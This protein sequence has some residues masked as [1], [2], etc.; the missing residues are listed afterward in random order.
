[1][2]KEFVALLTWHVFKCLRELDE[3]C[4]TG[5]DQLAAR[6]LKELAAVIALPLS[7]LCRR[8]LYEAC[9]PTRWKLHHVIPIFRNA[10][11]YNPN[12][13]RGVHL[14]SIVSEVVERV[15]GQPLLHFLE[16]H[17]FGRNQWAFRKRCSAR[18]LKF[19]CI[20]IGFSLYAWARN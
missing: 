18:A 8:I 5:P 4:A 10:S 13:Y 7:I 15:V 2:Q 9:W 12:N 3:S 16:E 11:V 6:I 17:A 19:T 20:L 14:T 1:M